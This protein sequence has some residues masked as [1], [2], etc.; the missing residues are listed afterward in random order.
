MSGMHHRPYGK[1]VLMDLKICC[2]DCGLVGYRWLVY[3]LA[4][5]IA[6]RPTSLFNPN[7]FH[8]I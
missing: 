2:S 8:R 3:Q 5:E 1:L 4:G 7:C 6:T